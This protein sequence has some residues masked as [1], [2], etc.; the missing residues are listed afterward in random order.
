MQ[1]L[2][3][4]IGVAF[5]A[6]GLFQT[7]RSSA[8]GGDLIWFFLVFFFCQFFAF[9]AYRRTRDAAGKAIRILKLT[10]A[11]RSKIEGG[12]FDELN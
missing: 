5:L 10:R 3:T 2:E 6:A 8:R 7:T 11:F 12:E 4:L 1:T 9:R